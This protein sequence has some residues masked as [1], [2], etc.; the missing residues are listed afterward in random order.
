MSLDDKLK[1]E[2]R[3]TGIR[4]VNNTLVTALI[5]FYKNLHGKK[6]SGRIKTKYYV[7]S[8]YGNYMR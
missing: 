5:E 1:E 4:I 2:A 7:S 3:L 8:S 6:Y